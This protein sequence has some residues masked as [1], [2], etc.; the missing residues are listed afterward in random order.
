M[1][2][3][4][5]A[6][7]QLRRQKVRL[8]VAIAGVAFAVIL[9]S[10]QY[11]FRDALYRSAVGIHRRLRADLVMIHPHYNIVAFPTAIPRRRLYQALAFDGVESVTPLYTQLGRWKN[12]ETGKTRDVFVIGVDPATVVLDMPDVDAQRDLIRYPDVVLYDALSRPE[13]G[14]V[15]ATVRGGEEL[16]TEVSGHQVVVKGLFDLGTSFGIDATIVTSDGNF[17]RIFPQRSPGAI[18]AGLVRLRPDA[19]ARAVRDAIAAALPRDVDVL[20]KDEYVEREVRYWSTATPIG[21][22]FQFGVVMG[23]VVGG[24]IVYQI[25]FA[26][27]SDHLGEYA[28]MKAMGYTNGYLARVVLMEALILAVVGYLPGIASA[29]W[30]Y[31]LTER[32]TMLPMRISG[33]RALTVFWLTALMCAASGLIAMRKLRAADPAEIF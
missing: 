3:A 21:Y 17:Q 11:G 6:W 1:S 8:V 13:F 24:I 12:P 25:L 29:T 27:I 28:T 9:I 22:V 20:T 15:A 26:D 10:M 19:D 14:P 2:A 33:D 18:S 4:R 30:L 31:G 23:L 5:L 7:L 16:A 32:A